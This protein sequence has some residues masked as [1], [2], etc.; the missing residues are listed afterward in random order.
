[1]YYCCILHLDV[2]HVF[3]VGVPLHALLPVLNTPTL[4]RLPLRHRLLNLPL[5]HDSLLRYQD[6]VLLVPVDTRPATDGPGDT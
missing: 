1:M 4:F 6:A 3:L 5:F 2:L